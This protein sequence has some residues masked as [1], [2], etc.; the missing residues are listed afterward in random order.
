MLQLSPRDFRGTVF[1][2]LFP[3]Q[4]D[5]QGLVADSS[6]TA[7]PFLASAINEVRSLLSEYDTA[8]LLNTS[9]LTEGPI[10]GVV[11]SLEQLT[12]VSDAIHR[13][14][15]QVCPVFSLFV[16]LAIFDIFSNFACFS[17]FRPSAA[18]STV[19]SCSLAPS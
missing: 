14:M 10:R 5:K 18:L 11:Y 12:L 1:A 19:V 4:P 7:S 8:S 16:C 9:V 13:G 2:R 15:A 6:T 17:W 3:Y